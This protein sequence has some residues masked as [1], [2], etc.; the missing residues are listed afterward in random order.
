MNTNNKAS[1]IMN[2]F[3]QYLDDYTL[4]E[5]FNDQCDLTKKGRD[6]WREIK[7]E[8]KESEE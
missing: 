6:L 8:L 7:K 2:I 1:N 5:F 3:S 4:E